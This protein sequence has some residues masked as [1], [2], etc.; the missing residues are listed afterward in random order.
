MYRCYTHGWAD[1]ESSCPSCVKITTTNDIKIKADAHTITDGYANSHPF[2]VSLT[3][4]EYFAAM[5][6]QGF[7]T[8]DAGNAKEK[9]E[10]AVMC[11][12]AL[13]KELNKGE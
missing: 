8:V 9:A 10:A 6:L 11:A 1:H 7:A 3:K 13:I 2:V 12:D 5:A 4:R